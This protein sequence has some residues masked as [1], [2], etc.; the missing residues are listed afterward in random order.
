MCLFLSA[1]AVAPQAPSTLPSS[2]AP[3]SSSTVQKT[4]QTSPHKNGQSRALA[5]LRLTEQARLLLEG[6][7]IDDAISTLERAIN[8]N[9]LNGQNYYYLAEAWFKKANI[10]QA[11]ELNRLA[12]MYLRDEPEWISR[13]N[14]Q[15]E[16]IGA[17]NP[18]GGA[19]EDITK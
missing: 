5:S 17:L 9:P 13:V 1:C 8:V 12:A 10:S 11:K 2:P 19:Q 15:K 4:D 14:D 3:S 18:R 7:K 6:G 16:R